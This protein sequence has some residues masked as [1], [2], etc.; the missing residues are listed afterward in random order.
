MFDQLSEQVDQLV[1]RSRRTVDHRLARAG[2]DLDHRLA[3]VR[4]LS[5]LATLQR[6]YA[7]VQTEA[8]EV[9]TT[10]QGLSAG[11]R[12]AARLA[13]GRLTAV[14]DAVHHDATG[15]DVVHHDAAGDSPTARSDDE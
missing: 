1:A 3:R 8:G 2:D 12:V 5:P 7:V 13:T 4:A 14:V 6:G 11:T 15:D 10:T 9:I